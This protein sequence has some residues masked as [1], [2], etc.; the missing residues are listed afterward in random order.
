MLVTLCTNPLSTVTYMV[1]MFGN[2]KAGPAPSESG[3][4]DLVFCGSVDDKVV[5]QSYRL[6]FGEPL[7]AFILPIVIEEE[8]QGSP[9]PGH[10]LQEFERRLIGFELPGV[11]IFGLFQQF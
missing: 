2:E 5:S 11:A 4:P 6:R 9:S 1:F 10:R 7:E 8:C 3:L